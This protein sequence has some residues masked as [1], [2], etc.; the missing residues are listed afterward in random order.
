MPIHKLG[1]TLPQTGFSPN[2]FKK[3]GLFLKIMILL[4]ICNIPKY[5]VDA[6]V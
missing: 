1:K 4:Y 6:N 3:M 5:F 2:F